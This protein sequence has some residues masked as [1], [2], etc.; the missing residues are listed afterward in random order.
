MT[1]YNINNSY[2][3]DKID[4]LLIDIAMEQYWEIFWE[5][6]FN[7]TLS[8]IIEN[9]YNYITHYDFKMYSDYDFTIKS[10]EIDSEEACKL[11]KDSVP[12]W[13][14]DFMDRVGIIYS[15]DFLDGYDCTVVSNLLDD[16]ENGWNELY[17]YISA[18]TYLKAVNELKKEGVFKGY[19]DLKKEVIKALQLLEN[20]VN[21][22]IK[23]L[24]YRME[25]YLNDNYN[26]VYSDDFIKDCFELNDDIEIIK[27]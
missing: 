16:L 2:L 25:N 1:T 27:N 6:D 15:L 12:T 4:N 18:D 11:I 3:E 19:E 24:E 5:Y 10:A 14:Y 22:D 20:K 9:E 8:D 26:Y 7:D 23:N 21:D 13:L 17:D